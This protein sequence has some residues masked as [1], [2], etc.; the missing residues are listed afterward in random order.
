[1]KECYGRILC[2]PQTPLGLD[3]R[4]ETTLRSILVL[5]ATDNSGPEA[6]TDILAVLPNAAKVDCTEGV[7]ELRRLRERGVL[8]TDT[9]FGLA[10]GYCLMQ[11]GNRDR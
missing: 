10:A 9:F 7:R 2:N 3:C 6:L 1:M 4:V 8:D 11:I 5:F